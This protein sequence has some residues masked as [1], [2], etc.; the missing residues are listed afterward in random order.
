MP[1]LFFHMGRAKIAWWRA[2]SI[3][4]PCNLKIDNATYYYV[5]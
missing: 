3:F 4:V 1:R 2:D 5:M